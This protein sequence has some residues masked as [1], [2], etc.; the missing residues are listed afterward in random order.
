MGWSLRQLLNADASRAGP[1]D[2]AAARYGTLH[3]DTADG[4]ENDR[5][6]APETFQDIILEEFLEVTLG[7]MLV[8]AH[9]Y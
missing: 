4:R 5:R 9:L 6:S 7:E 3:G 8:I 2:Q 1:D